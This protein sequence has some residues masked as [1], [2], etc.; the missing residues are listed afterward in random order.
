MDG[1]ALARAIGGDPTL[2]AIP[3]LMLSA[4]GRTTAEAAR[5]R[6]HR[7]VPDQA[8]APDAAAATR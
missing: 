2:A 1:L 7:G 8:G 6:R 3:L 5:A 4:W